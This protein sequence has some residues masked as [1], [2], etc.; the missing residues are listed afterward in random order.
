[1]V[2]QL[3]IVELREKARAAMG[4]RFSI[5]EFHNVVLR[6]GSVLPDVLEPNIDT[7]TA[8]S[9]ESVTLPLSGACP[10][11][12]V[13]V[14][15]KRFSIFTGNSRTRTPVAWCTASVIAAAIPARP[16]SPTPRAPSSL[17]SLSG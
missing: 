10:D 16:I 5:R 13:C 17:I 12:L 9:E 14:P 4:P 7:W 6:S 1:M 3:K 15:Y 2:G 11:I 8:K